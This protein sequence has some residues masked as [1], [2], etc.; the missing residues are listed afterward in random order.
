MVLDFEIILK[1]ELK[2]GG[3]VS[4]A[5]LKSRRNLRNLVLAEYSF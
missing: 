5:F 2:L 4:L 3:V 1:F